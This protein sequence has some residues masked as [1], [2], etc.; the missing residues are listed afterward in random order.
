MTIAIDF[1]TVEL[2]RLSRGRAFHC[3]RGFT[4]DEKDDAL[5]AATLATFENRAEFDEN[6]EPP[7][8]F[9]PPA[10]SALGGKDLCRLNGTGHA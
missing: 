8:V 6:G 1:F 4:R 7:A 3:L 10:L 5:A 2:A 9:F